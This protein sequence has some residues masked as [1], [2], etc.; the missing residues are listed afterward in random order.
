MNELVEAKLTIARIKT[1]LLELAGE[2][3][4]DNLSDKEYAIERLMT[5]VKYID[6]NDVEVNVI[7]PTLPESKLS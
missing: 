5:I 3:I 7:A 1:Q 6:E 2:L 4:A